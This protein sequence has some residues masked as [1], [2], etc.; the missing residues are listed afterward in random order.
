M[1]Y[2]YSI[3]Q[4]NTTIGFIPFDLSGIRK[5]I[6]L[7]KK[8]F[9]DTNSRNAEAL[10]GTAHGFKKSCTA[11]T[12]GI[13]AMEPKGMRDYIDHN[14]LKMPK[15]TKNENETI[16]INVYKI[17]I[18]AMLNNEQLWEKSQELAKLL[19]DA[20][21][22]TDKAI[23]TKRKNLVENVLKAPNKKQFIG[24][25]SEIVSYVSDIERF[26]EIVKEVHSMPSDNVPYFLALVRF[27]YNTI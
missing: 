21:V 4:T 18:L 2:I 6:H 7:Y 13:K 17:W 25:A 23:S 16:S 12:I 10:W 11:G 15:A 20:S 24:S 19:N 8:L 27:Q 26:K 1:G 14:K 9:G 22:N 3:G 5:P